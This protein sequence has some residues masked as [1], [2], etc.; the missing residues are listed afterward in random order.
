MPLLVDGNNLLYA[1]RDAEPDRPPDR[2]TL[3]MLL[4]KWSRRMGDR[5][6]IVFDGPRPA[7]ARFAQ[8]SDSEI[9]LEFSG[10]GIIADVVLIEYISENTAPKRLRVVTS[11]REIVRA[12]KKRRARTVGS[13]EFWI[14]LSREEPVRQRRPQEPREKSTGLEPEQT[15]H[16]L[17]EL[18][19]DG[20]DSGAI[21]RKP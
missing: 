16:W 20:S 3:C 2:S 4:G 11:D 6:H 5:V 19:L 14:E 8:I 12:A 10:S 17:R 9:T 21:P 7:Q 18:G 15:D 13:G 1:A